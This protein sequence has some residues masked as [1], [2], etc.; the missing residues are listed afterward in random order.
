MAKT[1]ELD[2]IDIFEL[3]QEKIWLGQEFLTW[4]WLCSEI[5]NNFT[6]KGDLAVSVWFENTLKLEK[7]EGPAKQ[8]LTCQNSNQVIGHEWI[9]AFTGVARNKQVSAGKLHLR[10]EDKEW[11]LTLPADTLTPKSVKLLAGADFTNSGEDKAD[12]IGSLL[13]KTAVLIELNS[14]I[15]ALLRS[16]LELR[17]SKEWELVELPRLRTWVQRWVKEG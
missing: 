3:W 11:S 15:E 5:D 12:Q 9:E 14:V 10:T 17:L 4:L 16:F 1:I 13:D 6:L 7:G 8:Q 2:D